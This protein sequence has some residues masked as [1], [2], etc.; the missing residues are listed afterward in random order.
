MK[1]PEAFFWK[2]SKMDEFTKAYVDEQLDNCKNQI[3]LNK[4]SLNGLRMQRDGI[5][6]QISA[7]ESQIAISEKV[8]AQLKLLL[9]E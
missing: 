9:S 3:E 1:Y 4:N 6:Q 2:E 7:Y 8:M 5:N